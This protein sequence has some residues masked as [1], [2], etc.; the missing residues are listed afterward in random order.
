MHLVHPE[1][2]VQSRAEALFQVIL[3][4]EKPGAIDKNVL[5]DFVKNAP[6]KFVPDLEKLSDDRAL[7]AWRTA[8]AVCGASMHRTTTLNVFLKIIEK[9]FNSKDETVK[10]GA[11]DAWIY[12]M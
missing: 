10:R 5:D 7:R 6:A 8:V 2:T 12:L 11:Y 9:F 4:D 3:V 1:E